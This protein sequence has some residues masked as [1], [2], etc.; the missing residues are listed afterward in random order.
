MADPGAIRPLSI[1]RY[2]LGTVGARPEETLDPRPTLVSRT[3]ETTARA[4][5]GRGYEAARKTLLDAI[6]DARRKLR[7]VADEKPLHLVLGVAVAAFLAGV[8][9]RLWRSHY[10]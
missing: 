6:A 4:R 7:Y 2:P 1:H 9:L 8:G 5:S 10:E 3:K